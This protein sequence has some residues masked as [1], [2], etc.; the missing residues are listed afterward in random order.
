MQN[1]LPKSYATPSQ[2]EGLS[3]DAIYV[4]E[5]MAAEDAGDEEASDQWLALAEIPAY[6]LMAC[7][8]NGGADYIRSKGLNTADADRVYG[9]GWLDEPIPEGFYG[10]GRFNGTV[11]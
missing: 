5:S 3:Q 1:P 6:A 7:K 4:V 11:G 2:L 10:P 9:P 8:K